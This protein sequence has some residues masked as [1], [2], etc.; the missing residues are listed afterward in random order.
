MTNLALFVLFLYPA[1]TVSGQISRMICVAFCLLCCHPKIIKK[2]LEPGLL[3]FAWFAWAILCSYLSGNFGLSLF[4]YHKRWEGLSTWALAISFGWLAWRASDLRSILLT[5]T[6]IC[7]ICLGVMLFIPSMFTNWIYT[8]VA[9]ASFTSMVACMLMARHFAWICLAL[10]FL[11]ITQNRTM[12]LAL[13]FGLVAYLAIN[14]KKLT[15]LHW[16]MIA[17]IGLAALALVAPKLARINIAG[18]GKGARIQMA[19]QAIDHITM[20][21]LM[22]YGIDT[23]SKIFGDIKGEREEYHSYVTEDGRILKDFLSTDRAHNTT[24]DILLQT[25]FVGLAIWLFILT[26][27]TYRAFSY[28]S[29]VNSA[30]LYGIAAFV[31]FGML[32]PTG[33]PSLFLV[34]L[35]VMGMEKKS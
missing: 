5:L 23:Q 32:N 7:A 22:G 13:S 20:K 14:Y 8:Y 6:A 24:L 33:I 27:M 12:I 15:R 10:P 34:C 1:L 29:E 26:R 2:T 30:C 11:F 4:G 9:I 31:G 18:L 21:P 3:L 28:P 19:Q 35:C 16:C 17:F 25:G